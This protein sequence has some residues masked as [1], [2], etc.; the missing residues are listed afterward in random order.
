MATFKSKF[1]IKE[2]VYRKSDI[3]E[4]FSGETKSLERLLVHGVSFY[5]DKI[6]YSLNGKGSAYETDLVAC[7][8][9][10]EYVEEFIQ[11]RKDILNEHLTKKS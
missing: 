2:N 3:K 6:S 4:Y 8:E 7:S 10:L 5:T 1:N 9:V 11:E